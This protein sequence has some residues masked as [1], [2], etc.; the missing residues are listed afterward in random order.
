MYS[1]NAAFALKKT[2]KNHVKKR[3]FLLQPFLMLCEPLFIRLT[4][5]QKFLE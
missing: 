5:H 4:E 1:I 2:G 3:V